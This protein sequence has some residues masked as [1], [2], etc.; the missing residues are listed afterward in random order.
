MGQ[1]VLVHGN[2]WE[3]V[4]VD[5]DLKMDSHRITAAD[6]LELAG[7]EFDTIHADEYLIEHGTLPQWLGD[8]ETD[9]EEEKQND[10]SGT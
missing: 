7:I 3:G 8:L 10:D 9:E 6:I 2:D 4:Y 5:E 1:I